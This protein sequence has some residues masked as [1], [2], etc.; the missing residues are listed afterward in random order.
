MANRF[1]QQFRLC[2]EKQPVD[3]Y[4]QASFD[5]L[6]D[7]TL[8]AVNSKGVASMAHTGPGAYTLTLQ[9]KYFSFITMDQVFIGQQPA[10]PLM[11]VVAAAPSAA[12]PVVQVQFL[13]VAGAPAD[14][15]NLD[16]VRLHLVLKN[17][18]AQ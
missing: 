9:D 2:L 11:Y 10:A 13:A 12:T 7:A 18:S 17:S 14:P 16:A 1:F 15:A 3:L 4:V 8:S 5:A 6:G